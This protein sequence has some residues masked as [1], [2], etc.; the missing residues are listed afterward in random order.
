MQAEGNTNKPAYVSGE[1]VKIEITLKNVSSQALSIEQ[2]PPILSLMQ[3]ET[4][5]PVYT[6]R[7]GT[8]SRT[9]APNATATYAVNWNQLDFNGQPVPSGGYYLELEDLDFQGQAIQL[10]FTRTVSFVI[11]PG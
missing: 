9:L 5:Q 2:F 6:F 4:R 10:N 3:A 1:D 11:Q 7:A 8:D